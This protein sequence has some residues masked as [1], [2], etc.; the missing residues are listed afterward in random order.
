MSLAS[1]LGQVW[2]AFT[3]LALRSRA[4]DVGPVFKEHVEQG[5]MRPFIGSMMVVNAPNLET[6]RETLERD[7]FVREGI[8][9]WDNVQILPFQTLL[10]RPAYHD[11]SRGT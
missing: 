2:F 4:N 9:D 7:I 11:N 8:W 10:R 5:H 1:C 3:P 6:V